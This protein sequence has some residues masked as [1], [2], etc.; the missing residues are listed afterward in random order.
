MKSCKARQVLSS[1]MTDPAMLQALFY[2]MFVRMPPAQYVCCS[3]FSVPVE[4]LLS[5]SCLKC[6]WCYFFYCLLQD[7]L[8]NAPPECK[9]DHLA[10]QADSYPVGLLN[11][12][13]MLS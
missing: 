12:D 13:S 2:L 1:V 7:I 4:T 10:T 9:S 8:L 3:S 11:V 5:Q 6:Q